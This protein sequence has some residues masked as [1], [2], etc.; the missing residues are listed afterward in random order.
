[1]KELTSNASKY[2][3]RRLQ[4]ER[5]DQYAR[6]QAGELTLNAAVVEAGFRHHRVSVSTQDPAS[7]VD[8]LERV[9]QALV[10]AVYAEIARRRE[11][12]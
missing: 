7:L 1:M 10:A 11:V 3:T 5:P 4:R 2:L 6:V 9:D 8:T 12:A